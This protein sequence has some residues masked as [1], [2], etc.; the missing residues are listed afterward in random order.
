MNKT[1]ARTEVI[2]IMGTSVGFIVGLIVISSLEKQ[3]GCPRRGKLQLVGLNRKKLNNYLNIGEFGSCDKT[4]KMELA[5]SCT[6]LVFFSAFQF[7]YICLNGS[8]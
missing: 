5:A 7:D 8:T 4:N 1:Q 2:L 6:M 3:R